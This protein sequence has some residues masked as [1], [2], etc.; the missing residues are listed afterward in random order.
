MSLL[1]GDEVLE[2]NGCLLQGKTQKEVSD[3]IAESKHLPQIE[4]KVSRSIL[5]RRANYGT[6]TK[7]IHFKMV[8]L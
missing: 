8:P 5:P 1:K 2:W 7:G 6:P 4:L 3:I